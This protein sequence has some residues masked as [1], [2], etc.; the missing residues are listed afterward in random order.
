MSS[1][2]L[3]HYRAYRNMKKHATKDTHVDRTIQHHEHYHVPLHFIAS[4][5][6]VEFVTLGQSF[7]SHHFEY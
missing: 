1:E 3:E 5:P 6:A 4:H 7:S 2:T